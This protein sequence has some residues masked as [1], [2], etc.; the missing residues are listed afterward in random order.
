METKNFYEVG[1]GQA[2]HPH[3]HPITI[4]TFTSIVFL[5][6]INL[7]REF[8]SQRQLTIQQFNC[9][10]NGCLLFAKLFYFLFLFFCSSGNLDGV[11]NRGE[12][13]ER[14]NNTDDN[15]QTQQCKHVRIFFSFYGL[16][17]LSLR[18][19]KLMANQC[20]PNFP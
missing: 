10:P 20:G 2:S 3:P 12:K 7:L 18:W 16:W 8:D 4:P 1:N 19:N 17:I 9:K 14:F 11:K 6:E 5:V 15:Y 13:P